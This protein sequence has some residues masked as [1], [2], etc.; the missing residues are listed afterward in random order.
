[1]LM[2]RGIHLKKMDCRHYRVF[3]LWYWSKA[4]DQV[5]F[6]CVIQKMS[7]QTSKIDGSERAFFFCWSGNLL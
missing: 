1:M 6:V 4:F 2:T 7:S 3:S 5:V